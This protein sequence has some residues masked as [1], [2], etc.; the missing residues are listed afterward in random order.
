M[1]LWYILLISSQCITI[2]WHLKKFI[3]VLIKKNCHGIICGRLLT[4]DSRINKMWVLAIRHNFFYYVIN[5]L[6]LLNRSKKN[7]TYG[8]NCYFLGKYFNCLVH[9][10]WLNRKKNNKNFNTQV[11][12]TNMMCTQWCYFLNSKAR[13]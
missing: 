9:I 7:V 1:L 5:V 12:C 13:E 6:F 8:S 11:D 4:T 2:I 10:V 3:F